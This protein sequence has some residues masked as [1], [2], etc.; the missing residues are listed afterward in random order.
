MLPHVHA[1]RT[2]HNSISMRPASHCRHDQAAIAT[3]VI[4]NHL[5]LSR[6]NPAEYI[7]Q[8]RDLPQDFGHL[9]DRR[10]FAKGHFWVATIA[11]E[12]DD[13]PNNPSQEQADTTT[14]ITR[15]SGN[16]K[17]GPIVACAGMIPSIYKNAAEND[18]QTNSSMMISPSPIT[19]VELTAVSM[20]ATHRRHG[21]ARRL[22]TRVLNDIPRHY[23]DCQ[24]V[25]LVTLR[26]RMAAACR[27]YES[28]GFRLVR[29]ERVQD[30]DDESFTMTVR[31]YALELK[32]SEKEQE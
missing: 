3:L 22:V 16:D 19:Q 30:D 4:D 6:S 17:S 13:D 14:T 23:P 28:L 31:Y 32:A 26:E 29:E 21:L 1:A 8:V 2:P 5:Q 25:I 11:K 7:A 10:T 15:R 27:L 20:L 18:N 12:D 24:R 9:L